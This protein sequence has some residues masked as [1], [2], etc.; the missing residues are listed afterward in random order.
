MNAPGLPDSV[1]VLLDALEAEG[2]Q[3]LPLNVVQGESGQFYRA[4]AGSSYKWALL[5]TDE[6]GKAKVFF[7]L[8]QARSAVT[9]LTK[10]E[11]SKPVPTI[12]QYTAVPVRH[13][14]EADRVDRVLCNSQ[15][16]KDAAQESARK[17]QIWSD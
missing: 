6:V 2:V 13:L 17:Q 4:G 8:G 9:R 14:N 1:S 7:K 10:R 3:T 11:P 16:A 5:W 12:V 15:A